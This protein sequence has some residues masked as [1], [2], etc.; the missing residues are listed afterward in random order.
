[1]LT[2]LFVL[3]LF[4]Q[5]YLICYPQFQVAVELLDSIICLKQQIW[6][7]AL[8]WCTYAQVFTNKISI[9]S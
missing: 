5:A 9:D 1:M 2:E 3:Q 4:E 8:W 6:L 7:P